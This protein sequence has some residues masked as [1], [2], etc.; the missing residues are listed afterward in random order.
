MAVAGLGPRARTMLRDGADPFAVSCEDRRVVPDDLH[1]FFLASGGVAGT[2]IGLLFVAISV[3]A[4]RLARQEAASQFY[5]IRASAALTAFT[6]P[7][8]VSLFAL[9]PG[10][11]IGTTALVVAVLGLIFVAAALVSLIRRRLIR[12][13]TL[14]DALF[15]VS[16]FVVFVIQLIEGIVVIVTPGDSGAVN[17]IAVLVTVCFLIG[18]GQAWELVGGPSFRLTHEVSALV[19]SRQN[20][21]AEGKTA[22]PA[23]PGVPFSDGA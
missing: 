17:A 15:L 9:I 19:H 3:A 23:G 1:E 11:R 4:D 8:A 18:V 5:R 20:G 13:E 12:R 2:L 10:P 21:G 22:P 16:L 7:L 14:R 6:N